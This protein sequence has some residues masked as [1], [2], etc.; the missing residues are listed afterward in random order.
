MHITLNVFRIPQM[1]PVPACSHAGKKSSKEVNLRFMIM[2]LLKTSEAGM[3]CDP[4]S[5]LN[6]LEENTVGH[7]A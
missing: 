4:I 5:C 1:I 6:A 2:L 3:Q 7:S